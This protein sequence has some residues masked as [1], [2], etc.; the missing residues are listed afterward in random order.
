MPW[1]VNLFSSS[2]VSKGLIIGLRGT[3]GSAGIIAIGFA[4]RKGKNPNPVPELTSQHTRLGDPQ[5]D[6]WK[7][8]S[9]LGKLIKWRK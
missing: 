4:G 2:R 7:K 5:W 9:V 3:T 6:A 1:V 8:K